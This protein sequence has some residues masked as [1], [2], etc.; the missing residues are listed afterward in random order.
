MVEWVTFSLTCSCSVTV[1]LH[2][3]TLCMNISSSMDIRSGR[4]REASEVVR[5][6]KAAAVGRFS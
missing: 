5:Y 2:L 3:M 4:H 6:K 1:L